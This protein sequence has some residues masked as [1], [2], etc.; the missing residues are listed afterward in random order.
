MNPGLTV[1]VIDDD[2]AVLELVADDTEPPRFRGPL[3]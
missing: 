3:V 1:A 2:E